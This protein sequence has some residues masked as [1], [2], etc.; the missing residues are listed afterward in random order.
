MRPPVLRHPRPH[1]GDAGRVREYCRYVVPR[2][3]VFRHHIEDVVEVE[4]AAATGRRRRR[5]RRRAATRRGRRRGRRSA[6]SQS[7]LP[8]RIPLF[9]ESSYPTP[10]DAREDVI[11][12]RPSRI[13]RRVA[14]RAERLQFQRHSAGVELA[15]PGLALHRGAAARDSVREGRPRRTSGRRWCLLHLREIFGREGGR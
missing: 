15:E 10:R 4:T 9:Q 11:L 2:E 7:R 8:K 1:H 14:V 5:R 12:H 6:S 13:D 3:S